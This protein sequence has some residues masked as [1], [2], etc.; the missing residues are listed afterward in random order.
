MAPR[1]F[2]ELLALERLPGISSDDENVI[3][4]TWLRTSGRR[5]E[6]IEFNVRLGDGRAAP[7]SHDTAIDRMWATIT[8][9]RAD[10]IAYR[11]PD[12]EIIEAKAHAHLD[13]TTQ[14]RLYV[15][16]Y[17]RQFPNV[18]LVTGRIVCWRAD[19]SVETAMHAD[20]GTVER[21][22]APEEERVP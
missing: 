6:R 14:V 16:M 5:Y 13:A 17:S 7:A 18:G 10:A 21:V 15:R 20:G 19:L 22:P 2:K 4:R 1:N 9:R 12:V 8:K 11:G 3:L